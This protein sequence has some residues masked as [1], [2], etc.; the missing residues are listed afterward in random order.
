MQPA[1][2]L[3]DLLLGASVALLPIV[4]VAVFYAAGGLE[5]TGADE[6]ATQAVQDLYGYRPWFEPLWS[7]PAPTA[8]AWLFL[9]QAAAGA[10]ALAFAIARLRA[11]RSR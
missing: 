9:G 5:R 8:E 3:R 7:P 10:A 1:R 2:R 11:R 4:G 6:Q